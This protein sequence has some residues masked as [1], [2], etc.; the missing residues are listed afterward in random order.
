MFSLWRK[1]KRE[2]EKEFVNPILSRDEGWMSWLSVSP[3][4]DD[5]PIEITRARW[6]GSVVI[7]EKDLCSD[8]NLSGLYWRMTGIY[9]ERMSRNPPRRGIP[10]SKSN[11]N[12]SSILLGGRYEGSNEAMKRAISNNMMGIW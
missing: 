2:E 5:V 12:I 11:G 8:D 6:V 1:K 7:C 10:F 4:W 3:E 9:R